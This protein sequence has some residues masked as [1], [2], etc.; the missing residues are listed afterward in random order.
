M[1]DAGGNVSTESG[2]GDMGMDF[3]FGRT[4]QSG[5]L[6]AFGMVA[7]IPIGSDGLSSDT[8]RLGP[9]LFISQGPAHFWLGPCL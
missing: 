1:A 5:L 4:T 7:G 2:F 3:V 9:E 6:T 8:W